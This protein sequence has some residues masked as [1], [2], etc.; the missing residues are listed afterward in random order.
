MHF[1]ELKYTKYLW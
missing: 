1:H